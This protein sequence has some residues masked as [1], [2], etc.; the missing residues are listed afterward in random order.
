MRSLLQIIGQQ[1]ERIQRL[2]R[3]HSG[4]GSPTIYTFW[5]SATD[6]QPPPAYIEL[7]MRTW[8]Q[9]YPDVEIVCLSHRTLPGVV[10]ETLEDG[11]PGRLTLFGKPSA[12]RAH[13][14]FMH[15]R[16]PGN[17]LLGEWLAEIQRRMRRYGGWRSVGRRL[18]APLAGV[19][20][21]GRIAGR[22]DPRRAGWNYL[23]NGILNPLLASGRF[24]GVVRILDRAQE[25]FVL[26]ARFLNSGDPMADYRQFYF[27]CG[28]SPDQVLGGNRCGVIALH[29]SWTP[30]AYRDASMES[31]LA[32]DNLLS[33][34]LR[35]VLKIP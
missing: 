12:R 7:C 33:G 16:R 2:E 6:G 18:A 24:D 34:I 30:R 11:E 27:A 10:A 29:N 5:E 31:I 19:P 23:S 8:R 13:V 20:G 26:E 14:A 15:C 25:G 21:L 17:P 35:S 28:T 3:N 32:A 1:Q 4:A 22:L 9:A